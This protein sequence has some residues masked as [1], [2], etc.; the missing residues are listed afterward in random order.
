AHTRAPARGGGARD[1]VHLEQVVGRQAQVGAE[2]LLGGGALG[3][4]HQKLIDRPSHA[5]AA[6]PRVSDNVGWGWVAPPISHGAASSSNATEA[7]AIR[8]VACG[9]I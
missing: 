3:D 8:S 5:I 9:P 6:S 2:R 4:R 1:P 7:A